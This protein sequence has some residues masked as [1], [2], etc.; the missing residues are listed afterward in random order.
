MP[1]PSMWIVSWLLGG[2]NFPKKNIRLIS[3]KYIRIS[4]YHT[5]KLYIIKLIITKYRSWIVKWSLILSKDSSIHTIQKL[6]TQTSAQTHLP[7]LDLLL[8]FLR[9]ELSLLT[10]SLFFKMDRLTGFTLFLASSIL[11][12]FFI[13]F[14]FDLGPSLWFCFLPIR[15]FF[16]FSFWRAKKNMLI[17]LSDLDPSVTRLCKLLNI[18]CLDLDSW[19]MISYS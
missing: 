18:F 5:G 2:E 15:I 19:L 16:L 14:L 1:W 8:Y 10:F 13:S 12:I 11:N 4:F 6:T 3:F 9:L 17:R 7:L